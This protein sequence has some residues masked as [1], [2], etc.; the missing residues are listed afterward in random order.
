MKKQ[1]FKIPTADQIE[2][3]SERKALPGSD[4]PFKVPEGYFEQLPSVLLEKIQSQHPTKG[5]KVS[6]THRIA[7]VSGLAAAVIA[8]LFI[9]T[10]LLP[11]K[12]QNHEQFAS[13]NSY[14]DAITEYLED[15][16]DE[17]TLVEMSSDSIK[18]FNPD[19]FATVAQMD[20]TSVKQ[21]I[22]EPKFVFDTTINNNDILEYLNNENIDPEN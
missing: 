9:F 1:T 3:E 8:V 12:T 13:L 15:N 20:D 19:E 22:K 4:N 17:N 5:K 6:M 21:Q 18:F 10:L 11:H 16:L 2:P 7:L 14:E